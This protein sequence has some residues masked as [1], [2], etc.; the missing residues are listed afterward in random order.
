MPPGDS[1]ILV[2]RHGV[3]VVNEAADANER[4]RAHFAWDPSR[5]EWSNHLLF[6]IYDTRGAELF[7]GRFPLPAP[8]A[9][10][11]FVLGDRK[12]VV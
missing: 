12:S 10:A 1:T 2:N 4:T 3:R 8:G 6:L 7:G 9:S 5:H 11:P